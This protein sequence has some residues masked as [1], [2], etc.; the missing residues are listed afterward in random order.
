MDVVTRL[1][2]TSPMSA[3]VPRQRQPFGY[4]KRRPIVPSSK[5]T[6]LSLAACAGAATPTAAAAVRVNATRR[7]TPRRLAL[8]AAAIHQSLAG[9]VR[10][11]GDRLLGKHSCK[12]QDAVMRYRPTEPGE[13]RVRELPKSGASGGKILARRLSGHYRAITAALMRFCRCAIH[14]WAIRRPSRCGTARE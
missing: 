4:W 5:F 8:T 10:M 3:P 12:I 7:L 14:I 2:A 6:K 9:S 11:V 1:P 13:A